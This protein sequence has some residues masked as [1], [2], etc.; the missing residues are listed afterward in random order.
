MLDLSWTLA[1]TPSVKSLQANFNFCINGN[2]WFELSLGPWDSLCKVGLTLFPQKNKVN[3]KKKAENW[4]P[5]LGRL[6][7]GLGLETATEKTLVL[8]VSSPGEEGTAQT[9]ET[10]SRFSSARCRKE[11]ARMMMQQLGP[12]WIVL[13]PPCCPPLMHTTLAW[14]ISAIPRAFSEH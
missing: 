11:Q 3:N 10:R 13:L 2:A 9:R 4:K 1:L 8:W 7:G 5:W 12:A 6:F 14:I